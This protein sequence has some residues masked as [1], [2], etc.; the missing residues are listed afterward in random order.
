MIII[1]SLV[2]LGITPVFLVQAQSSDFA[3]MSYGAKCDGTTDDS[4][5]IK[6]AI[7]A[8]KSGGRIIFPDNKTCVVADEVRITTPNIK[9][10]GAGDGR[11]DASGTGEA[12]KAI[13]YTNAGNKAGQSRIL[14]NTAHQSRMPSGHPLS[15]YPF[16]GTTFNVQADNFSVEGLRFVGPRIW[17]KDGIDPA[18]DGKIINAKKKVTIKNTTFDG[19]GYA[20]IRGGLDVQL[21]F[22]DNLCINWGRTCV[23]ANRNSVVTNSVFRQTGIDWQGKNPNQPAHDRW[24]EYAAYVYAP[25]SSGEYNFT[26]TNNLVEGTRSGVHVNGGAQGLVTRNYTITN[27]T[28]RNNRDSIIGSDFGGG[29]LWKNVTIAKNLFDSDTRN[30]VYVYKGTDMTIENNKFIPTKNEGEGIQSAIKFIPLSDDTPI[31]N[32]TVKNNTFQADGKNNWSGVTLNEQGGY[33]LSLPEKKVSNLTIDNNVFENMGA[34]RYGAGIYLVRADNGRANGIIASC[35]RFTAASAAGQSEP[36][37][38]IRLGG[39]EGSKPSAVVRNAT[40]KDNT[41]TGNGKAK[42]YAIYG[43]N[44][45][46]VTGGAV[47]NNLFSQFAEAQKISLK[48]TDVTVTNG[49]PSGSCAPGIPAGIT[50]GSTLGTTSSNPTPTPTPTP[51]S[52]PAPTATPTTAPSADIAITKSVNKTSVKSGETIIY[53]ITIDNQGDASAQS[54]VVTD[55]LSSHVIFDSASDD[56]SHAA[57]KVTWKIPSLPANTQKQLT[58]TVKA[59]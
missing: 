41:F 36:T 5:A 18:H 21:T 13:D 22:T 48:T 15:K 12:T 59:K 11:T 6:A 55:A 4:A 54:L 37:G 24:S 33:R 57:G 51:T 32:V 23:G 8:A 17:Y 1:G 50:L 31:A 46:S 29:Q 16:I 34:N 47:T 43:E 10:V 30:S 9:L 7:T 38:F 42:L 19:V 26:F 53:T 2:A 3:I 27:N 56:G 25:S 40:F 52:T 58:L 14:V 49:S 35:N 28:F 44:V 45:S 39:V 20:F